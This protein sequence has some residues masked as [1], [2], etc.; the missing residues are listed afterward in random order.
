MNN[1]RNIKGDTAL[2]LDLSVVNPSAYTGIFSC[3]V[4]MMLSTTRAIALAKPLY[5]VKEHLVRKAFLAFTTLLFLLLVTKSLLVYHQ[6][7]TI[8]QNQYHKTASRALAA[9]EFFIVIAIVIV[10]IISSVVSVRALKKANSALNGQKNNSGNSRS[11]AIMIVTLS[12][13]F[14]IFNATWCFMWMGM[15]I[16]ISYKPRNFPLLV[17]ITFQNLVLVT[18][19]SCANP[20]VYLVKNSRLHDYTKKNLLRL[21][22][23]VIG[24]FEGMLCNR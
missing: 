14:I 23:L 12:I 4:T 1:E 9:T 10:V 22:K 19:N 2:L 3:F 21:M 20:I 16:Y 5:I 15:W 7:Q 6:Y 13:T 18:L 17:I 11:A 8:P 24:T